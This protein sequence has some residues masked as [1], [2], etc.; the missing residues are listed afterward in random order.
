MNGGDFEIDLESGRGP[1]ALSNAPLPPANELARL[2]AG[3]Q[4]AQPQAPRET[5]M[6]KLD[7]RRSS[8]PVACVFHVVFKACALIM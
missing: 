4:A 7:L 8:H 5:F 3:A 1:K 6:S 2:D